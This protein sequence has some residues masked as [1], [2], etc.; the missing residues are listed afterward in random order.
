VLAKSIYPTFVGMCSNC[1]KNDF[2]EKRTI[3]ITCLAACSLSIIL[4]LTLSHTQKIDH[5]FVF[6]DEFKELN[7]IYGCLCALSY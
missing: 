7:V 5:Q 1:Y 4:I 6:G 3:N 2:K